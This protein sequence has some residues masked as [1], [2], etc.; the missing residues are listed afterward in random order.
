MRIP[1]VRL[2]RI[3]E[4]RKGEIPK[5]ITGVAVVSVIF[6]A[7]TSTAAAPDHHISGLIKNS[8]TV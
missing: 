3:L 4:Y 8:L 2:E 6:D 5:T 7:S 1:L